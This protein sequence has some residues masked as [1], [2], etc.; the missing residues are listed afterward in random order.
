MTWLE[1]KL[2]QLGTRM[3][4]LLQREFVSV[5]D[6]RRAMK[7]RLSNEEPF[8]SRGSSTAP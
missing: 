4:H 2:G 7:S 5:R 3:S 6:K 1:R 8:E